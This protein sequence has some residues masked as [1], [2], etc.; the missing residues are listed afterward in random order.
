MEQVYPELYRERIENNRILTYTIQDLSIDSMITWSDDILTHIAHDDKNQ[1]V[2][3]DVSDS[4]ASFI[5]LALSNRDLFNV[6]ITHSGRRRLDIHLRDVPDKR[7]FLAV[8]LSNTASGQIAKSYNTNKLS[9]QISG[10]VFFDH[11]SALHWLRAQ[12]NHNTRELS[13]IDTSR[14]PDEFVERIPQ[15]TAPTIESS[16]NECFLM[17]HGALERIHFKGQ[18]PVII[19]REN[20]G[21]SWRVDID[22]NT[23]GQIGRS[24][25]RRH[26]SLHRERGQIYVTDLNSTNGTFINGGRIQP[27][28]KIPVQQG[29]RIRFGHLS[30][31][32]IG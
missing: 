30:T 8:V 29:S 19:G 6:G 17:I 28:I 24:V 32:L 25:S 21:A 9:E 15:E 1:L 3:F 18:V 13:N 31:I 16:T 26:A 12:D 23:Y 20:S 22:L 2:L 14:F 10:K 4:R 11:E 7:I 5:Y 27:N